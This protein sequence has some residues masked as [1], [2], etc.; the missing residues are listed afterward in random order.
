M[1]PAGLEQSVCSQTSQQSW[2]NLGMVSGFMNTK[3]GKGKFTS[4]GSKG[5]VGVVL[6]WHAG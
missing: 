2:E 6:D 5:S 3:L 4:Q 1:V